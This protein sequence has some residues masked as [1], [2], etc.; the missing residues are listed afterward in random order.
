M[1]VYKGKQCELIRNFTDRD[2]CFELMSHDT[3]QAMTLAEGWDYKEFYKEARKAKEYGD[4]YSIDGKTCVPC[5][6]VLVEVEI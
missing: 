6:G 1:F 3:K 5:S 2:E 4:I